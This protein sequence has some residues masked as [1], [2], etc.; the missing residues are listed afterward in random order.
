MSARVDVR[1]GNVG[2]YEQHCLALVAEGRGEESCPRLHLVGESEAA[3]QE[4]E[5]VGRARLLIGLVVV[6]A[7][8]P[9]RCARG[10]RGAR[11]DGGSRALEQ[12]LTQDGR[13]IER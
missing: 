1:R 9:R 8:A 3:T 7:T 6:W 11:H 12:I 5:W 2:R 13:E 10:E 4:S